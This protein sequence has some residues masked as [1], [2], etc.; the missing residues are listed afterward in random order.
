MTATHP[1]FELHYALRANAAAAMEYGATADQIA[2]IV[3]LARGAN[4]Y[5]GISG[6]RL[7]SAAANRI[8]DR[9]MAEGAEP[10]FRKSAEELEAERQA[11]ARAS[12][13][14]AERKIVQAQKKDERAA[15]RA[16]Y[17]TED[18]A[19]RRFR[20]GAYGRRVRHAR[21]GQGHVILENDVV[22][23]VMFDGRERP[24]CVLMSDVVDGE[25]A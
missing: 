25:N 21:Y 5:D 16:H 14:A 18:D 15:R 20:A 2:T 13:R 8:I 1:A 17:A 12:K 22:I 6:G 4:A 23:T 11:D 3:A 19:V 24:C 9:M 7:T 10:E